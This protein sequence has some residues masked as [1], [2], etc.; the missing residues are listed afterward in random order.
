MLHLDLNIDKYDT[1]ESV[2][3]MQNNSLA[4]WERRYGSRPSEVTPALRFAEIVRR[5]LSRRIPGRF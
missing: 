4:E 1:L 5:G 2:D 3:R